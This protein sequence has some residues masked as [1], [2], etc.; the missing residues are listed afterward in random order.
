MTSC[1]DSDK[2][3]LYEKIKYGDNDVQIDIC[4][5]IINNTESDYL[6]LICEENIV[7]SENIFCAIEEFLKELPDQKKISRAQY[8]ILSRYFES[9][10][11]TGD[12]ESRILFLINNTF[13]RKL[14]K[15]LGIWIGIDEVLNGI[16]Y[17]L[18]KQMKF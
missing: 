6:N 3:K 8:D 18:A 5:T 13:D 17:Q 11:I 14:K 2:Y 15:F 16:C 10:E 4:K 1:D 12:I 7:S 9:I